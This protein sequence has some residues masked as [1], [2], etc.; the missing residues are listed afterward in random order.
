MGYYINETQEGTP[1]PACGKA[2]A[3]IADGALE[4]PKAFQE[5]LICVVE[6]GPFDAAAYVYS[7]DE[8]EDF[9]KEEIIQPKF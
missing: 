4:V 2:D 1:L 6:N 8:F 3:L 7:E 5:N 9:Y